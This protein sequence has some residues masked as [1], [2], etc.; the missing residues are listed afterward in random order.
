[1]ISIVLIMYLFVHINSDPFKLYY[2]NIFE[3]YLIASIAIVIFID[4][5]SDNS[6]FNNI[7]ISLLILFPIIYYIYFILSN[8]KSLKNINY[9]NMED[10]ECEMCDTSLPPPSG[11]RRSSLDTNM[12]TN[13]ETATHRWSTYVETDHDTDMDHRYEEDDDAELETLKSQ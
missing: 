2:V 3:S 11:D 10:K 13:L 9:D 1:M 8:Y 6:Q 5:N 4:T 12:D 7:L